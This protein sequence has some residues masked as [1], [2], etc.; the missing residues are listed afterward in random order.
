[1]ENCWNMNQRQGYSQAFYLRGIQKLQ[2]NTRASGVLD[3]DVGRRSWETLNTQ[4]SGPY[5]SWDSLL[6]SS[7]L[8]Q[9]SQVA[10]R[11]DLKT[12]KVRML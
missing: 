8:C 4:W 1:M 9:I 2:L 3:M 5:C 12:E 6:G 11:G 10:C 7:W